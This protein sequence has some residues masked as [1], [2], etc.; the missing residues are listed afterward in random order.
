MFQMLCNRV[1]LPPCVRAPRVITAEHFVEQKRF[2]LHLK[3]SNSFPQFGHVAITRPREPGT[4]R[5]GTTTGA[6]G[7]G[8]GSSEAIV[9]SLQRTVVRADGTRRTSRFGSCYFRA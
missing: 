8:V 5:L 4:G 9:R 6:V 7:A 3:I 1:P 2:C